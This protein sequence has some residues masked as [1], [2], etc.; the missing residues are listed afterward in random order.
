MIRGRC[1][2]NLDEYRMEC[3]PERFVAVPRE[4]EWIES[5]GGKRLKVCKVTHCF[6]RDEVYFE[7]GACN[8]YP[9]IEI[10]LTKII[11]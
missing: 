5:R 7:S 9:Y 11:V 10:E 4:G 6:C 1:R 2:T 3:W 8:H